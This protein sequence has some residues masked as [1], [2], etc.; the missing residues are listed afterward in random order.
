MTDRRRAG[1]RPRV[2]EFWNMVYDIDGQGFCRESDGWRHHGGTTVYM[3]CVRTAWCVYRLGTWL[4]VRALRSCVRA[5][6]VHDMFGYD[7]QGRRAPRGLSGPRHAIWHGAAA[8]RNMTGKVVLDDNQRDAIR[9]HMFPLYPIP[10]AHVEGW[11]LTLAD[12][13]TATEECLMYVARRT[14]SPLAVRMR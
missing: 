6:M 3:H 5:A 9:K 8:V 12:K 2:H 4:H 10:P 13:I 11:L 1:L 7:W 14:I